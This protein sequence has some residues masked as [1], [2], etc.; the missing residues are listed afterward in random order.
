MPALV[1]TR[2]AEVVST[3]E[4]IVAIGIG[5]ATVRQIGIR[6]VLARMHDTRV[7]GARVHVLAL[8]VGVAAVRDV[9]VGTDVG[10][11]K[12]H[13][14][15]IA[16]VAVL[17]LQ[18]AIR[19]LRVHLGKKTGVAVSIAL[20]N[21]AINAVFAV[22]V[23]RLDLSSFKPGV[24]GPAPLVDSP[25]AYHFQQRLQGLLIQ[26]VRTRLIQKSLP[27]GF[28]TECRQHVREGRD[29]LRLVPG[30]ARPACCTGVLSHGEVPVY[31]QGVH[32]Q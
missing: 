18:A 28:S 8:V 20:V 25:V 31:Y 26:P 13:G 10:N 7:E 5:G 2:T 4:T 1:R 6:A 19:L 22:N 29:S 9:S 24:R 32:P 3:G 15:R 17:L 27:L 16:V 21:G 23:T 14:A 12:V 30:E 11:A